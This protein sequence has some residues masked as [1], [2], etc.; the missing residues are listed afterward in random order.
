MLKNKSILAV[1]PARGGSKGIKL[2]NIQKI[3]GTPL[4]SFIKPILNQ[5]EYIDESVVST[6]SLEIAKVAEKS[7]LSGPFLRP[8]YLSGDSISDLKV[9]RHALKKM[10]KINK[11]T[12]DIILMLQP[13][14]PL[15]KSSHINKTLNKLINGKYDSVMT[16]SETDSKEHP[17]K[18][19]K[20]K[21]DKLFLFDKAGSDIITRQEL[22]KVYHRNGIAYAFTRDC[23]VQQNPIINLGKNAS[24]VIIE[25]FTVNIDSQFDM[26]LAEFL[27]N[28]DKKHG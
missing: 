9:L 27:I 19:L 10:E 16:V 17:L 5:L 1:I 24:A 8:K 28:Y 2:K 25:D 6:D 26:R 13:T 12:Y 23:L 18:Q 7:G 22:D 3:N 21:K 20:I 14:S 15:R 4:I 11:I